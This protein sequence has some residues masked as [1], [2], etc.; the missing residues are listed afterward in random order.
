MFLGDEIMLYLWKL[1]CL[2]LQGEDIV[3]QDRIPEYEKL[4]FLHF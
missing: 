4:M 3:N 2:Q 1:R